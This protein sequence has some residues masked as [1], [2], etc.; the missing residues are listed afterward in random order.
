[1]YLNT[2]SMAQEYF[3]KVFDNLNKT[4]YLLAYFPFGK[5]QEK[6]SNI[7]QQDFIIPFTSMSNKIIS[8]SLINLY[9]QLI[10]H[11]LLLLVNEFFSDAQ[12]SNNESNYVIYSSNNINDPTTLIKFT[13]NWQSL[14]KPYFQTLHKPI[15]NKILRLVVVNLTNLLEK[16]LLFNLNKFKINELG[17]IKLEKDVSYLINEI[18]QDNYYLREKFVRL[19]Q[20]VLLVG[21]DDEEYE[22]SNQPVTKAHKSSEIKENGDEFDDDEE[23]DEEDEE[24]GINWVLTPQERNQIRKYRI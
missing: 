1:M 3:T 2:L 21:M 24:A 19:T 13:S 6:I 4:S 12:T 22:D 23:E 11:R 7:L 10:K 8:E 9:N 20:I 14:T 16:K 15:W 17:S 18:C 5:D